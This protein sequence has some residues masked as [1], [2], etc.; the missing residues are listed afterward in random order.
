[1]SWI[2]KCPKCEFEGRLRYEN[3]KV[4]EDCILGKLYCPKCGE[5]LKTI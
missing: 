1:V 4:D 5:E 3:E 2:G